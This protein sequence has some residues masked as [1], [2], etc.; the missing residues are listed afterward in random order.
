MF[1][2]TWAIFAGVLAVG[3]PIAVHLLTR[4]RPL[5]MP[6][7]TIRFVRE[8]VQQRSA[9]YRLRDWIIFALRTLAVLLLALAFARPLIGAKPIGPSDASAGVARVVVLDV[10]QS[11]AA[12]GG[13]VSA[14]ERARAIAEKQLTGDVRP[15]SRVNLILAGATARPV[16]DRLTTNFAAMREELSRASVH[17]ERLNVQLSINAA[18]EILSKSA[19]TGDGGC[20]VVIVSDFQRTNWTSVD[21]SPIP[22]DALIR[23]ES[24]APKQAPG[25][26]AI[27]RASVQGRLEPNREARLEVEIGNYSPVARDVQVA[28]SLGRAEYTLKG[29]CPPG[30]KTTLAT[31]ITLR[32]AGW[33]LG[34]ARLLAADDALPADDERA[35][36]VDVRMPPTYAMLTRQSSTP[37]PV[38]S[39][40]LERALAPVALRDANANAR[41]RVVRI[42]P[43]NP[44]PD[45]LA[46]ADVIVMDHPGRLSGDVISQIVS[47]ARRGKA[48]LYL[49]AEPVDA[50]NL[51]LIADAAGND[52]RLPVE[53]SPPLAGQARRD[54]FLVEYKRDQP[55]FAT[56]GE[57]LPAAIGPLRFAGGL[58]SRRLDTGL[59]DDVL[60]SYS[61]R[62]AA[63]VVTS[64]GAGRLAILNADLN[65]SDLPK[66]PLFVPMLGE[67]VGRLLAQRGAGDALPCGELIAMYLPPEAGRADGLLLPRI[68]GGNAGSLKEENGAV[69]WHWPTAGAPGVYPIRRGETIVFA[70]A[71]ATPAAESDLQLIDPQLL[72]GR[73]AGGRSVEFHA[74]DEDDRPRDF[75]WSWVVLACAACML[76]ELVALKVLRT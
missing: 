1:L 42:D 13:G 62:S 51:K 40:F 18:A 48:V 35:F 47:L 30:V 55:P 34:R 33:Q 60:A 14:F 52:L 58:N 44:A 49:A 6:L 15:G 72:Q 25:N 12:V 4:P 2:N 63:L 39:H 20:E 10:S 67:L 66:S 46:A 76:L 69:T 37:Q 19:R 7:S 65:S 21:F 73:L 8:V 74:F 27:L 31:P 36:V 28:A 53:F 50:A 54:L 70:I 3:L 64:C 16:F 61:D 11:M 56:F 24:A 59:S 68:D 23:L 22:K 43:E 57:S 17:P 5:R 75:A 45:A 29:T 26:L 32:D 41:E 9:A 38:S 71:T